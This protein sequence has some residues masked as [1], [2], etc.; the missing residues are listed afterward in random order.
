MLAESRPWKFED[1]PGATI[2]RLPGKEQRSA[3]VVADHKT[4]RPKVA[5][6]EQRIITSNGK[7]NVLNTVRDAR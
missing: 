1:R 2:R 5:I 6:D 3:I 7:F 4:L